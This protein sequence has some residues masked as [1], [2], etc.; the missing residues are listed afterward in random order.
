LIAAGLMFLWTDDYRRIF[1][2]AVIPGA[3]AVLLLS[4]GVKEPAHASASRRINPIHGSSLRQLSAA[5]WWVVVIGTVFSLA[6]FSEAFLVLRA[7]QGG[8]KPALVPLVMVA[9]NVVYSLSAYP[10]GKL[11]DSVDHMRLLV[12]GLGFLVGADLVLAHGTTWVSVLAGMALWG[13]H[14]GMT[15][16]LLA[17]M[18]AHTAPPHLKGTAFG[19]F[20]LLSGSATLLASVIAGVLWERLGPA[21]TFHTGALFSVI[22]AVLIL[23]HRRK[24]DGP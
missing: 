16:G 6:R 13:L 20:N 21:T 10:F 12:I 1:W 22:A 15:Q 5:Y 24:R 3:L 14:M 4:L 11:A 2:I 9:M 8:I 23:G 18:V 17:V 7:M 19:F